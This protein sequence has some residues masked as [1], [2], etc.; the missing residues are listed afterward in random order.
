MQYFIKSSL[1]LLQ[2]LIG[3]YVYLL[4]LRFLLQVVSANYFNP[5]IQILVKLTDIFVKPLRRILPKF[6]GFD[7]ATLLIIIVFQFIAVGII[8]LFQITTWTICKGVLI[9]MLGELLQKVC[10][11]YLAAI[12]LQGVISWVPALYN[13]PITE[14][15]YRLTAP[16]LN[17]A[18]RI[19]PVVGGLDLSAI[20]V[21][22]LLYIII[23]IIIN[24]M[25]LYGYMLIM[26]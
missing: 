7:F 2:S 17:R 14:I 16:I 22:F 11:T 9:I 4:L 21:L 18:R 10:Y 3:I 23:T 26:R 24:P 20:P 13:S 15:V 1:Y 25:I 19:I 12:I 6:R 8:I 5:F